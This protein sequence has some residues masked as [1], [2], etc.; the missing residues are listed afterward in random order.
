MR[1]AVQ[2]PLE[3]WKL[4]LLTTLMHTAST[5][6]NC[7]DIVEPLQQRHAVAFGC[8]DFD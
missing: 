8:S 4:L 2:F 3:T 7:T 5:L 6:C 1:H